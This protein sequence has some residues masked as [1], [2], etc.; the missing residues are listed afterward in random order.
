MKRTFHV[1]SNTHWDREWRFPFQRNRQMLVDMIDSLLDILENHPDYRAF[2]LD[3]QSIVLK[4]YLEIKPHNE[5]RIRNLILSGRLLVGP[6]YILPDEF[7]VGGE[8]LIRNLLLGHKTSNKY[9]RVSKIGY[10]PFSWGQI[11][12]LPQIYEQFKIE[13][14]MFYRG[15]NAL[16]SEKAEFIWQGADGTRKITSRFSTMPRYNFYFYIYRP[17]VHNEDYY[18]VDYEWTRGGTPYHIAD[19]MQYEEDYFILNPTDRLYPENIKPWTEKIIADQQN[20]FT[21]PHVIW[22]EG[23]DSSGPNEKTVQIIE[24]IR[25]QMPEL[26]VRHSTLEEY[27]KAVYESVD[28]EKL[29]VVKGER[30]SAQY[31][32]RS[33]NMYAYT[34][35]ARMYLKQINFDTERNLQ[36]FAEPLYT[37]AGLLGKDTNDT[38]LSTAWE[39]VI[40]NSAHDS[41]GGCSLDG[42]H[43][44]MLSRYKAASEISMGVLDRA[45]KFIVNNIGTD[46]YQSENTNEDIYLTVLNTNFYLRNEVVE[47]YIDI[48]VQLDK[49]MFEI[50]DSERNRIEFEVLERKPFKPVLEQMI[51]RPMYFDMIRYK[52][53]IFAENIPQFG[54]KTLKINPIDAIVEISSLQANKPFVLENKYLRATVNSNGTINLLH[55]ESEI[56]YKNLAYFEDEGEAGHAWVHKVVGEILS[57]KNIEAYI[58]WK[59]CNSLMQSI[60]ISHTLNIPV[61]LEA[62]KSNGE[63]SPNEMEI[64]VS[65]AKD[66]KQLEFTVSV[67]NTSESHRLRMMFPFGINAQ[68]S[69][70]EGQF[71]VVKR[72]TSRPNT[73][74]WVEQPMYDFPMH[75]FAGVE[76]GS[77]G[78]AI[79]VDGL[80]EYE[81]LC[82]ADKTVAITLLRGFEFIISPSSEQDYTHEKGSQC[83]GLHQYRFALYPYK[84]SWENANVYSQALN[85]NNQ[86]RLIQTGNLQGDLEVSSSFFSIRAKNLIF[87]C[88]K[89]PENEHLNMTILRV[90]NPTEHP[91]TSMIGSLFSIEKA[92]YMT[93]EEIIV[94]KV[95][96]ITSNFIEIEVDAKKIATI[97]IVLKE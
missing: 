11:S 80:K 7:L 25:K 3:S 96:T 97:G 2:H 44:D 4:D 69:Y 56:E 30:R 34:T 90:Y 24:Q 77:K 85:F 62:R 9:G 94:E 1:I 92:F 6:W 35:S 5:S 17:A 68:Y 33:G 91:I 79:L 74:D 38:Y 40:Q 21:T 14:I 72:S 84:G 37:V 67:L 55:K 10:S 95:D 32:K 39:L 12:Q 88:L 28:I 86:L 51:N 75:Q 61:D 66:S 58:S 20:D 18:K 63:L 87:S 82:D 53:Q 48:P 31:N 59:E 23:H 73:Q 22:M 19:R 45:A 52:I 57:T 42:I 36:F 65:L 49:G 15:V 60:V 26:D 41:I 29:A 47:A 81:A 76:D 27:A 83:M 13:M 89:A 50:I 43:E 93:M 71:D 8:N 16:D 70:G 54:Y 46:I 64:V 78:V